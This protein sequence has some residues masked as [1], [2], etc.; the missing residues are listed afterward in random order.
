MIDTNTSFSRLGR[1]YQAISEDECLT[2][3]YLTSA[4]IASGP[5]APVA[6]RL[7]SI[8]SIVVE[9]GGYITELIQ[10][11]DR[12]ATQLTSLASMTFRNC[13][14]KPL[15][16]RRLLDTPCAKHLFSLSLPYNG[17]DLSALRWVASHP[18]LEQL[19]ALDLSGNQMT[20]A[21]FRVLWEAFSLQH[22]EAINLSDCSVDDVGL[23]TWLASPV[24]V[25]LRAL[26]LG[27]H[28]QFNDESLFPLFIERH[29][30]SLEGLF[31]PSVPYLWSLI[32]RMA[33]QTEPSSLRSF[34]MSWGSVPGDELALLLKG[35]YLSNVEV[36]R[37][38]GSGYDAAVKRA[39]AETQS[40][41]SLRVLSFRQNL[42]S[43]QQEAAIRNNFPDA[44]HV[45]LETN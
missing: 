38:D 41:G 30:Q 25:S 31:L 8:R 3:S 11:L 26:H 4:D 34:D 22:L 23:R 21:H 36:L 43:A 1:D 28:Q 5:F 44:E 24:C 6:E 19:V 42:L 14:L 39:L 17:L 37:L 12:V 10:A 27:S 16:V 13:S 18:S 45:L 7:P 9:G 15:Q 20:L 35:P 29:R 33:R 32:G 2:F 40:L